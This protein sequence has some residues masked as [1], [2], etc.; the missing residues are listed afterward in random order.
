MST[1]FHAL[2]EA[3]GRT[4]DDIR[5]AY[6]RPQ[7]E[8][9]TFPTNRDAAAAFITENPDTNVW[10][11]INHSRHRAPEG[12]SSAMDVDR[13]A[14]LYVDVDH[15]GGG[16]GSPEAA[17]Q[18]VDDLSAA[19]GVPP[20][21]IVHTGNGI[22]PY[23]PI[24]DGDIDEGSRELVAIVLAR[25]KEMCR[26]FAMAAGGKVDSVFDLPRIF[27]VPGSFNVKDPEHPLPVTVDFPDGSDSFTLAELQEIF[28]DYG[29]EAVPREI[30]TEVV[31][32]P[33][34][35]EWQNRDCRHVATIRREWANA[36]PGARHPW[37]LA[38]AAML[39][40]M[41]RYGC[42]T[43]QT[44]LD[45]RV[46]LDQRFQA[47]LAGEHP[48]RAAAP[49]EISAAYR[50]GMQQATLWS[51]EKLIDEMRQ[52]PHED[53]IAALI[54]GATTVGQAPLPPK[55]APTVEQS[56]VTDL[57]TRRPRPSGNPGG[58]A[59]TFGALALVSESAQARLATAAHTDTG[60]AE[61][62]AQE[63]AG[64][65]MFVTERGWHRWNG[66]IWVPDTSALHREAYKDLFTNRLIASNDPQETAWLTQSL[67]AGR[68][69]AAIKMAETVSSIRVEPAD[70]DANPYELVTPAGIYNLRAGDIRQ[71][72]PLVDRN[73]K[74]TGATPEEGEPTEFLKFLRWA[75]HDNEVLI[76]YVRRVLG[77]ALI[78]ELRSQIFP[79]FL[80]SGSN[81]KSTLFDVL[82]AILGSYAKK[83][84]SA[85]LVEQKGN[86][87]P[88]QVAGLSG[89]RL[90]LV[91]EIPP[92]ATF[93]EELIKS[94][95]GDRTIT[96]RKLHENSVTF[97]NTVT[98]AGAFNHLP[99][100]AVGGRS[101]WR[102]QRVIKMTAY[103]PDQLADLDLPERLIRNEGGRILNWIVG[104]TL[105]YLANGEQAPAE[106]L[107]AV[108]EYRDSE[109][110]MTR[111][112]N[113]EL[114]VVQPNELGEVGVVPRQAVYQ[115]YVQ[116]M[117]VNRLYASMVSEPKFVREFL[118]EHPEARFV[119]G[120]VEDTAVFRGIRL[121]GF[122][123]AP[124]LPFVH[125]N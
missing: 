29:I 114:E 90:A 89:V 58:D 50:W 71:A 80:G 16:M 85:F 96:A 84:S 67:N 10:F 13:L 88:E 38:Q 31:S 76:A 49:N 79:I 99:G 94:L 116:F 24:S 91:S 120:G 61:L 113:A 108:K 98:V 69:N 63:V 18:L 41:I 19:L 33:D 39:H 45:M 26:T 125:R 30:P 57:F 11:E 100:V 2:L 117:Q 3:I 32:A 82:L 115:R 70:M 12:R 8:F 93:D 72:N 28:D 42:L 46:E 27:R 5:I 34:E 103:M 55:P 68:T 52:H 9:H 48:P 43:E 122:H 60:N 53:F 1:S 107:S 121:K 74:T 51:K 75:F 7:G 20:A 123:L 86:V 25:W 44:F 111:F 23:W 109:D 47:L 56:N 36:Q 73:S 6:A 104:G 15:K 101:W 118:V 102:R 40:G 105:D 83:P 87:I 112:F 65:F 81:G 17:W 21:A 119:L 22:Q 77:I 37:L 62:Y 92:K 59:A 95:T 97:P 4:D 78:G 14:A 54:R 124:D 106:V 110:D 35:W 64:R 66:K